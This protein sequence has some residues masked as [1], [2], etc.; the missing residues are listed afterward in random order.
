MLFNV[1]V[2]PAFV[3]ASVVVA[4]CLLVINDTQWRSQELREWGWGGVWA[5]TGKFLEFYS[6]EPNMNIVRCP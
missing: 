5:L 6:N 2:L 3:I 1:D 4:L